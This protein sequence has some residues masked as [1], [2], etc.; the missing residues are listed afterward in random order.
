VHV[1]EYLIAI[2]VTA[3]TAQSSSSKHL[4]AGHPDPAHDERGRA[5]WAANWR[6]ESVVGA[7]CQLHDDPKHQA[8]AAKPWN[9]CKTPG[10]NLAHPG[11]QG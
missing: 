11:A 2:S 10:I 9:R 3:Q 1:Q 6:Q 8:L 7:A 5:T 4:P